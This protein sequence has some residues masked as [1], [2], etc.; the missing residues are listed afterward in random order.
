VVTA[1]RDALVLDAIRAS[2]RVRVGDLAQRLDLGEATVRRALHRLAQ[3]GRVIRTYGGA[4]L[5]DQPHASDVTDDPRIAAK[6]AIGAA[7]A[8]LVEDGD[9]VALSSGSTVLELARRLRDRRLTVITNALDVANAL[10]DAPRIELVV[11]GGVLL[12]GVHSL[13]GHLTEVAI[14]DLR[15]DTVFMGASAVDMEHGFMTEQV[16]EIPVD[17]ALRRMA[18]E[19]V[20]LVD[21]SK[22]DRVAPGFMFG[23]DHVGTVVSDAEVRRET[24][25]AL[26]GRGIRVVLGE[27]AAPA[28]AG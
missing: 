14:A 26:R 19:A 16:Q 20:L 10:L 6:R 28:S 13:G 25:A 18:R 12:P 22:F 23:L 4:V 8:A 2:G 1:S 27:G 3:E 9:T 11:L 15:A 7:A 5:P 17:R 21:A 24:V